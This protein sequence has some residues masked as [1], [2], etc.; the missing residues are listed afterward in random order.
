MPKNCPTFGDRVSVRDFQ[1]EQKS[2]TNGERNHFLVLDNGCGAWGTRGNSIEAIESGNKQRARGEEHHRECTNKV[3][4]T[5]DDLEI[6]AEPDRWKESHLDQPRRSSTV[7][8]A[9]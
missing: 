5:I 3:A 2:C 7:V 8:D 1:D 4:D 9:E 6:G